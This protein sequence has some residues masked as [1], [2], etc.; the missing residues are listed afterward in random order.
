MVQP[1]NIK[2]TISADGVKRKVSVVYSMG[3]FIAS[4]PYNAAKRPYNCDAGV[5]MK[6]QLREVGGRPCIESIS[7]IPVWVQ[8]KNSVIRVIPVLPALEPENREKYQLTEWDIK[9]LEILK[10]EI[11]DIMTSE[12]TI[13]CTMENNTYR[14]V[15]YDENTPD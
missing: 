12:L 11:P 3:N 13:P 2:E 7:F 15:L 5:I 10:E 6:Y 4:M 14:I 1:I 9:R 8:W